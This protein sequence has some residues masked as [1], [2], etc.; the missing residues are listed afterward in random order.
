MTI[1]PD[2]DL[3]YCAVCDNGD[4]LETDAIVICELCNVATH[5]SCYG[6]EVVPPGE[7]PWLCNRCRAGVSQGK[8][9]PEEERFDPRIL[10]VSQFHGSFHGSQVTY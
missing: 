3:A 8:Q 9:H 6:I 2:D 10:T 7:E 5:Q 4:S 1:N